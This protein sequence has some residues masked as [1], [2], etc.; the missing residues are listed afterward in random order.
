MQKT[1][2]KL[3]IEFFLNT[4]F[5]NSSLSSAFLV[6]NFCKNSFSGGKSRTNGIPVIKNQLCF[7]KNPPE[8]Q[9][10]IS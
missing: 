5:V 1:F 6:Q 7:A 9:F 2:Y 3:H 4:L 10:S 8:L